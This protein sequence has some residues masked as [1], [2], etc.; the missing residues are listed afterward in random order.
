MLKNKEEEEHK[1]NKTFAEQIFGD[2]I[3]FL[4]ENLDLPGMDAYEKSEDESSEE[5][6]KKS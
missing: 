5:E 3:G 1:D 2:N 6:E 4:D